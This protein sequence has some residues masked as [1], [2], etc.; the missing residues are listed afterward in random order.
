MEVRSNNGGLSMKQEIEIE[1]K[2]LLTKEEY[3]Q[4]IAY[5]Q[6]KETESILQTNYYF[7]TDSFHLKELGSAL[8]IR[9][10]NNQII[11]TL[12]TPADIGLLETS[13]VISKEMFQSCINGKVQIPKNIELQLTKMHIPIKDLK[14][15]GQL[16][17]YRLKKH[18]QECLIVLDHSLYLQTEDFELELETMDFEHGQRVF[19]QLLAENNIPK[20]KTKNKIQ[21]LF[22]RLK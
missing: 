6:L 7:E 3:D 8:R 1:F 9:E 19:L 18:Y 13:E 17:T 21:R 22:D 5:F 2:N 4:L 14:F 10:K 15:V 20:R 16:Q 12:K 11:F